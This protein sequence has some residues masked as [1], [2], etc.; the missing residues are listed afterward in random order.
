MGEVVEDVAQKIDPH[1]GYGDA[2]IT[3]KMREVRSCLP[4]EIVNKILL[5]T[6]SPVAEIFKH[7]KYYGAHY[8]FRKLYE[9]SKLPRRCDRKVRHDY[10]RIYLNAFL[11]SLGPNIVSVEMDHEVFRL[12]TDEDF[13]KED[14]KL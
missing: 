2:V 1:G 14:M 5:Y 10:Y 4:D 13:D 7:S 6:S 12:P 8:P 9:V 11:E 3:C